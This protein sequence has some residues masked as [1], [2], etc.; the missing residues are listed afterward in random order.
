MAKSKVYI[1]GG[2][3]TDFAVNWSR[4]G[5]TMFDMLGA[6]VEGAL[7]STAIEPGEVQVAHIGNFAGEVA[8]GALVI[9]ETRPFAARQAIADQFHEIS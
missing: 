4:S 2:Y 5:K 9:D 3:Q 1:L 8:Q 7:E 6:T